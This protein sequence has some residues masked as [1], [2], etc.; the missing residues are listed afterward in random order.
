MFFLTILE[1]EEGKEIKNLP[2]KYDGIIK[3]RKL[4]RSES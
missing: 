3:G 2:R 4:S 1:K